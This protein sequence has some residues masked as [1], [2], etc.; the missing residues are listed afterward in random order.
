MHALMKTMLM[1]NMNI[2]P[3]ICA[4]TN[5]AASSESVALEQY[6]RLQLAQFSD[7]PSGWPGTGTFGQPKEGAAS[8]GPARTGPKESRVPLPSRRPVVEADARDATVAERGLFAEEPPLSEQD[9]GPRQAGKTT[10]EAEEEVTSASAVDDPVWQHCSESLES[11]ED[12]SLTY[13]ARRERVFN[14]S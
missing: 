8:R 2:L 11:T 13:R 7:S 4:T 10:G 9:R 1:I 6:P 14:A 12:A 5:E 3:L